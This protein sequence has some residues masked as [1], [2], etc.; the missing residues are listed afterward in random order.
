MNQGRQRIST[1]DGRGNWN[2][3]IHIRDIKEE[4][5]YN[6]IMVQSF[7]N[8]STI[9]RLNFLDGKW[10][11]L[12]TH[13]I[14]ER[15]EGDLKV[16]VIKSENRTQGFVTDDIEWSE[17]IYSKSVNIIYIRQEKLKLLDI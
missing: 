13:Q 7:G 1:C 8:S 2:W 4:D 3:D 14:L 6:G 9:Y 15:Y 11:Y 5:Y 17:T 10:M 16:K 12:A